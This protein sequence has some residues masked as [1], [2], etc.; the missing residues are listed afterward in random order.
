MPLTA[1]GTEV[2]VATMTIF[3]SDS[4]YALE[5]TLNH[6]KILKLESYLGENVID[7]CAEIL[8]DAECLES[9]RA[10]NNE[11]LGCT[12]CIL[13]VTFDSRF[14]LLAIHKYKE[15][16]EFIKKFCVCDMDFIS[17]EDLITY[18]FLL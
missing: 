10:F 14:H 3:L 12:T 11:H 2:F 6:M 13:E 5:E 1:T 8:V 16:T 7:C 4:Y 18:D 9:D 17:R 15:V